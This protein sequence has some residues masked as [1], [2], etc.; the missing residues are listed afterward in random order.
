[1]SAVA[2]ADSRTLM[3]SLHSRP[4]SV[5]TIEVAEQLGWG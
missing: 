3:W 5:T 1:M 4:A 2:S